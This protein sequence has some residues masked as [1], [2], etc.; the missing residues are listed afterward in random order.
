MEKVSFEQF[1]AEIEVVFSSYAE[2]NDIDKQSIKTWLI[3][4]LRKFGKNICEKN[5]AIVEI[6]NSRALLP[7]N[8]KS[9]TMALKVFTEEDI[10]EKKEGEFI[11]KRQF[12][13]NPAI[14]DSVI[15]DY[16][17]NYCETKIVT[18]KIFARRQ[19]HRVCDM[20]ILSLGEY[21]NKETIDVDCVNICPSIR[22]QNP[23]VITI[24]NRTLN[25]NFKEGLVYLQYN[26]LPSID[27]EIA[28]PIITT[29]DIYNYLENH[30][31]A[32]IT[33]SLIANGKNPTSLAQL[34]QTYVQND[35][36]LFVLAQGEAKWKGLGD[37]WQK[38]IAA[39]NNYNRKR[40][41]L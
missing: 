30:I 7:E 41:G 26:S 19:H 8:F 4:A 22:N 13:E 3:Q 33:E 32:R 24:N 27:G 12:I 9:L 17:V 34:Y 28:L 1:V 15:Q 39:K 10:E 36:V 40:L 21:M 6:K 25:A 29:G 35:R 31:K 14:W 18:E 37:N 2:S 38:K 16:V 5:E 20:Q 23:N 11:T